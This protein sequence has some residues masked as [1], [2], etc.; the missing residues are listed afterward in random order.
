THECRL[1]TRRR[2]SAGR[3]DESAAL[4]FP[5]RARASILSVTGPA[6]PEAVHALTRPP[7]AFK[8]ARSLSGSWLVSRRRFRYGSPQTM[9]ETARWS[10]EDFESDVASLPELPVLRLLMVTPGRIASTQI[11]DLVFQGLAEQ[12][13]IEYGAVYDGESSPDEQRDAV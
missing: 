11:F 3:R 9:A 6:R 10:D 12:G 13:A 8:P 1:G 7:G 2:G 5:R 4:A